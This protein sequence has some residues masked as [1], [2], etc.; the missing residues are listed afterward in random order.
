M[1][2]KLAAHALPHSRYEPW[3]DT[4]GL[5]R[6]VMAL[7]SL[8]TLLCNPPEYVF[9]LGTGIASPMRCAG[10]E[11]KIG[12]FC[13]GGVHNL[14][15]TWWIA[16]I[17]LLLVASGWRPR[18]TAIPHWWVA[19]SLFSSGVVVDGGDQVAA[20]I[21]LLLIPFCLTDSRNWHWSAA[22][23][24]SPRRR[25][26]A[27]ISSM[28]VKFQVAVIYAH[29]FIGKLAVPEWMDGTAMYYWLHNPDLGLP[30]Y[31]QGLT[32]IVDSSLVVLVT[33][34]VLILELSLASALFSP[35]EWR[36]LLFIPALV[37]HAGIAV[38]MGVSSFAIIM[39]G[40]LLLYLPKPGE[41]L[42]DL[43]SLKGADRFVSY[44]QT[45]KTV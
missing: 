39:I 16:A 1:L 32:W 35:A 29:A 38:F 24:A 41:M 8:S 7:G 17:V 42:S 10:L 27:Q 30:R 19:S 33:W 26:V 25:V 3:T 18:I 14:R 4:L 20:V 5:A 23:E 40:V 43:V 37:F 6:T 21:T 11:G 34:S 2:E 22:T 12:L 9:R 13:I 36:R 31:L 45:P 44:N 28:A 15:T